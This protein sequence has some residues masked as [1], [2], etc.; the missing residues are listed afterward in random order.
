[1]YKQRPN[2]LLQ[3]TNFIFKINTFFDY[4]KNVDRTS[5]RIKKS[6]KLWFSRTFVII[7]TIDLLMNY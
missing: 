6:T 4:M 5:L 3:A 2:T 1:M 7:S